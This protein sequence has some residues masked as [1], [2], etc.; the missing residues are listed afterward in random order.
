MK[1]AVMV[2]ILMLAGGVAGC[3]T[4]A[5]LAGEEPWLIGQAPKR[6]TAPFGGVDNDVRWMA[7][8]TPPNTWE[9]ACIA[10][11]ALDMPLSLA[12][13]IVTL[14]ITIPAALSRSSTESDEPL[15]ANSNDSWRRFWMNS[16]PASEP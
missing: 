10:A 16:P 8:G 1:A 12:G 7:R 14:P 5:N 11:A 4:M 15:K 6:D 3:G 13:D 2:L 9:P